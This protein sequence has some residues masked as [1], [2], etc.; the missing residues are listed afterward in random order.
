MAKKYIITN[1]NKN[2]LTFNSC[3]K[4]KLNKLRRFVKK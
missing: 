2:I 3:H 1:M 4:N